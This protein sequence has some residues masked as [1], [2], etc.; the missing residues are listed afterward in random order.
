MKQLAE[1]SRI[2]FF[3][4]DRPFTAREEQQIREKLEAFLE[5]WTA[6]G[7]ALFAS[8]EIA[9]NRV[10]VV[11]VD[12]EKALA[13]GCSIDKLSHLFREL[14]AETGIDFFNRMLVHYEPEEGEEWKTIPLH[15]FW[16]MRKAE[17]LNDST[18]IFDT[19][20]RNLGEYI[21]AGKKTFGESWHAEMWKK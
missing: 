18:I 4:S 14:S 9:L 11:A 6:H 5:E 15:Q 20:V 3:Q 21:R 7:A 16:A 12:E 19:T 13:T 1:N 2:W 17:R 8:Y 10:A